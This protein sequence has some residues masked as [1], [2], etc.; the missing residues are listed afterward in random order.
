VAGLPGDVRKGLYDGAVSVAERVGAVSPARAAQMRADEARQRLTSPSL[1]GPTYTSSEIKA[2]LPKP[3]QRGMDFQPK[4]AGGHVARTAGEYAINATVPGGPAMRV[5][6]AAV[7]TFGSE[8]AGALA[9]GT[10]Y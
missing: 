5:A 2:M 1:I 10:S 3:M 7:P 4:A 9:R 8:G 6:A